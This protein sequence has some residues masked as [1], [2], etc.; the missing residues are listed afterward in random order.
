MA[1]IIEGAAAPVSESTVQKCLACGYTNQ[2]AE[3]LCAACGSSLRLK[4][5]AG[6]E[7]INGSGAERCHAC[8][9]GFASPG[10]GRGLTTLPPRPDAPP[11]ARR[12]RQLATLIALPLFATLGLA[13]YVYG[14]SLFASNDAKRAAAANPR[15]APTAALATDVPVPVVAKPKEATPAPALPAPPPAVAKSK[16]APEA[17][18]ADTVVVPVRANRASPPVAPATP[19]DTAAAPERRRHPWVTHTK[20]PTKDEVRIPAPVLR[21]NN[22]VRVQ[23][24]SGAEAPS[25]ACSEV[26]AALGFCIPKGGR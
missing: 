7:A 19:L 26:N 25:P 4:L 1:Q 23:P 10:A 13:Y 2:G 5:C 6:C 18:V 12:N 22:S 15:L 20:R 11:V 16:E 9:A 3:E 21:A 14:Q 24:V 17:K 8:G